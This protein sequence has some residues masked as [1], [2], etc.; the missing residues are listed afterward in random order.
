MNDLVFVADVHLEETDPE[1]QPFSA[2][3]RSLAGN[4]RVCVIVGDLFNVWL[5]KPRFMSPSQSRLL[6]VLRDVA[7]RGVRFKYVEG[8]RDYFVAENWEGDPFVQ[9]ATSTLTEQAGP[10]RLLVAHGDLINAA[11][12]PYR[13]WRALSRS[14]PVR[15]FLSLLPSVTGR[16][17]ASRLEHKLRGT[18]Q[19][20]KTSLPQ[21][22]FKKYARRALDS[23][24]QGVVLGHFHQELAMPV[25]GG[26]LW[27]LPDWRSGRRYLRFGP[28]G[29]GRFVGF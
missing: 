17:L 13:A 5:A 7:S 27:V 19:R 12:R 14:L 25:D 10:N 15:F 2:F 21:E 6:D 3:L 28:D 24:H 9:V 1:S 11:D 16:R 29:Q 18:N 4:T 23:G 26:T 20:H 22:Q 8:N